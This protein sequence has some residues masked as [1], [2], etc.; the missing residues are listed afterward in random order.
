MVEISLRNVERMRAQRWRTASARQIGS[1]RG[2]A[3]FISELGFVLLMSISATELPS[4]Q[5]ATGDRWAWWDWKQT[6]PGRKACYYAKILRRRG[7]FVA[8]EWFPIFYAAYADSRPYRRLYRDGL[9]DRAEKRVM[10]ILDR[11]GPLMTREVRLAFGARS[12]E[13]TRRV[14][15]VLVNLQTR[16]LITTAG[17]DTAGWSHHRWDLVERWVPPRSLMTAKTLSREQARAQ[18]ME[19]FVYNMIVT[20]PADVAWVFG[21]QRSEVESL[22]S[23]LR[24]QNRI[25]TAWVGELEGEVLVPAAPEDRGSG[26]G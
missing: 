11:R 21:W 3:R 10:D 5:A 14:K 15:S 19:G 18:I 23:E 2:A 8:W 16:F 7:T 6:L 24:E 25:D 9:L 4:I 26:R 22:V 13:N 12:R 20:T 17:G 1:E